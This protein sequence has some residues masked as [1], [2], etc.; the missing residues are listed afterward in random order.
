VTLRRPENVPAGGLLI[1][2]RRVTDTTAGAYAHRYPGT[3]TV[4]AHVPLAGAAEMDTAVAA[5][6]AALS[7]WRR[8]PPNTRRDLMGRLADLI[9]ADAA[10]LTHLAT[11]ENGTPTAFAAG[12]PAGAAEFWDYNAGWADK[13]S[14]EVIAT[15]PGAGFDYAT[16]EPYG[17]V[18]VIVP[19]NGPLIA[20]AQVLAPALAAGNTVVAKPP[21]LA[22]YT[23]LRIGELILEAGFPPGVVNIVPGGSEGGA[24]LVRHPDVDKI[25]FTG[26]GGTARQILAAAA[27]NLTPAAL[28]LGGKSANVIFADAD[29]G[30]A[31]DWA[32][33][34]VST[35]SGQVCLLGTRLLVQS[36]R[37]DEV[38]DAVAARVAG[39]HPGDPYNPMTAMGPV[40]SEAACAR[41]LGLIDRARAD[42]ALVTG[43]D[44]LGGELAD[45]YFIAPT[46]F[47]N[48]DNR[49]ELAQREV[50]GPVLAI[51]R[52]ETEA[53]GIA[54]A[55]ASEFGL[56]GY[57]H[58][59][60]GARAKRVAEA[61]DVGNVWINGFAG[62]PV[63][64]PYGGSKGSGY[65]R[66]GGRAGVQEFLQLKNVWAST[67]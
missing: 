11:A 53:E 57:V 38:V 7:V 34:A 3:G 27:E 35:L 31:I 58:T 4:T 13:I 51:E 45:G 9:R 54:L 23:A 39:I 43:G 24:A 14:G 67:S 15:W 20:L 64:I 52:F 56:A 26:S 60:D 18:A 33:A 55:N 37:Y 65:G 36:T 25:H 63:S 16:S 28:E 47:A 59:R 17:V 2:D 1:A 30:P 8:T 32:V 62:K 21:E 61:L 48:V 41:I 42:S 29:L 50:F 22:P 40:V 19:W 12:C 66:L 6:R 44:R 5:A 49:S 10:T 46:V